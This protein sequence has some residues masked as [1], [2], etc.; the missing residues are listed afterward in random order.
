M[1]E[2]KET[3]GETKTKRKRPEREKLRAQPACPLLPAYCSG[4]TRPASQGG[5]LQNLRLKHG[6]AARRS[7]L[8]RQCHL[9]FAEVFQ[10]LCAQQEAAIAARKA[11]IVLQHA[12]HQGVPAALHLQND[13]PHRQAL[14]NG[15][16]AD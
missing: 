14:C 16:H 5:V 2:N 4:P 9:A 6:Y 10:R 1:S 12:Q 7:G 11:M 3:R 8:G 15:P 13:G